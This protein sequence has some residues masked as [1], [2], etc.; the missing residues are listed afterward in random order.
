MLGGS[1]GGVWGIRVA[2]LRIRGTLIL[3][4][5][6]RRVVQSHWPVASV[7]TWRTGGIS[8]VRTTTCL[9]RM[10]LPDKSP[11]AQIWPRSP[12]ILYG[13]LFS[14]NL[15]SAARVGKAGTSIFAETLDYETLPSLISE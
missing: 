6:E 15:R 13:F 9:G 1:P 11:P 2:S 4:F 3:S 10:E 14:P 7:K 5:V 12:S 8:P